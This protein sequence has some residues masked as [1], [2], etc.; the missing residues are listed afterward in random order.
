LKIRTLEDDLV[1]AESGTIDSMLR[2]KK[3]KMHNNFL[4]ETLKELE[5]SK[6][7]RV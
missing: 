7:A 6:L 3:R 1:V 4:R 2:F 5:G